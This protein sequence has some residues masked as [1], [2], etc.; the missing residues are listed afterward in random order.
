MRFFASEVEL[1]ESRGALAIERSKAIFDQPLVCDVMERPPP[2]PKP[3]PENP[4]IPVETSSETK[5]RVFD[6]QALAAT[7]AAIVAQY[8]QPHE[9]SQLSNRE[10]RGVNKAPPFRIVPTEFL[11]MARANTPTNPRA[12]TS[13][14]A[15]WVYS[16]YGKPGSIE[17]IERGK[18]AEHSI[19]AERRKGADTR[20]ILHAC[21]N[22]YL[23]RH[24]PEWEMI[25]CGLHLQPD[26]EPRS[27]FGLPELSVEGQPLGASPDLLYRNRV[28]GEVVIVEIKMSRQP[29]P[30]NLWP[31]VWAQLWCYSKIPIVTHA[32]KV[33]VIGEVWGELNK[34]SAAH[35]ESLRWIGL[36]ASVRR[37]PRVEAYDKFFR[38]LFDI[39]RSH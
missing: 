7:L 16:L 25:H 28:T 4:P 14:F 38:S 33:T 34:W 26:T 6:P 36:R 24:R 30:S 8:P 35:N 27:Y 13:A 31:N 15:E 21:D 17:D 9:P 32:P 20:E 29:L 19:F 3:Q 5:R 12:T 39:Y 2:P 18:E 23:A 10:F 22:Q 37:D 11:A 1:R